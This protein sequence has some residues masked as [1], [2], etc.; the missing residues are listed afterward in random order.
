MVSS[1]PSVMVS[2]SLLAACTGLPASA[3]TPTVEDPTAVQHNTAAAV[4]PTLEAGITIHIRVNSIGYHPGDTKMGLALTDLDLS[5]RQF[6]VVTGDRILAAG[7]VGADRGPYAS[8]EHLY[9]LDFSSFS[10]EGAF[11]LQID[12]NRSDPFEISK[13]VY[14]ALIPLTI[15]F[16]QVQRC[17]ANP[18]IMHGECHADDGIIHDGPKKG[19]GIDASGGWHDAG[20][21]LKFY[22]TTAFTVDMML[23]AYLQQPEVFQSIDGAKTPAVLQEARVGLEWLDKMWRP[24][25][26]GSFLY[27][28]VGDVG[29]HQRWRLPEKDSDQ[30][31][32]PVWPVEEG[33]GAN[34]AGKGAA[35]MAMAAVIWGDKTEPYYDRDF[36]R[37]MISGARSLYQYGKK[38]PTVQ[39]AAGFYEETSSSDDM[40]FA[41]AQLYRATGEIAYLRDARAY[42]FEAGSAG[43]L[44]WNNLHALAHYE[45]AKLDPASLGQSVRFL[46]ADLLPAEILAARNPF[47]SG[48]DTFFWGV[49]L[50]LAGLALEAMW[51]EDLTHNPRFRWMAQRQ[52]DFLFGA[53]PWG[54]CWVSKGCLGRMPERPHHRIAD[55]SGSALPGFWGPGPVPLADFQAR[56]IVLDEK[57]GL[58]R[59]QNER[60]VYHDDRADYMTNEPTITMNA[61]GLALSAWLA[62]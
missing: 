28:Q 14:K 21:Y 39:S 12:E 3:A 24:A 36:A 56:D 48:V 34:L 8:F 59:F 11:Q 4:E 58:A 22:L 15:Q 9:E 20:D 52:R 55:L 53:N 51:F 50:N 6:E 32:R 60:A 35:A 7:P 44:D 33:K 37:D 47:F 18:A 27:Y 54:V 1:W 16:F 46:E 30:T 57:D 43:G 40:A 2:L 10:T 31:P 62:K 61:V 13:D 26:A 25:D 41:A 49:N 29:D 17:G 38:R 42:A 19:R 23:S 45:L 5:G